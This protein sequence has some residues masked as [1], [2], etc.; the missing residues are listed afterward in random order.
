MNRISSD[1]LLICFWMVFLY[2]LAWSLF[3]QLRVFP[4]KIEFILD[5]GHYLL[6]AGG[7]IDV[8]RHLGSLPAALLAPGF[9]SNIMLDGPVLSLCGAIVLALCGKEAVGSSWPNILFLTCACQALTAGCL[10]VLAGRLCRS[11]RVALIVGL[12]WAVYP[13]AV[14]ASGRFLTE[15]LAAALLTAIFALSSE[16]CRGATRQKQIR[17]AFLTGFMVGAG[18]LLKPVLAPLWLGLPAYALLLSGRDLRPLPKILALALGLAAVMAPWLIYGR[19]ATGSFYL[20]PQRVPA[21]NIAKGHD[22]LADGWSTDPG[23]PQTLTY[24]AMGSTKTILSAWSKNP[25]ALADLYL[26]KIPRTMA[27][28]WNDFRQTIYGLSVDAQNYLHSIIVVLAVAGGL[29]VILGPR[30]GSQITV[31]QTFI[32]NSALALVMVQALLYLPFEAIA[33]YGYCAVPALFLLA[34]YGLKQWRKSERWLIAVIVM[35]AFA[36]KGICPEQLLGSINIFD[37]ALLTTVLRLSLV[38]IILVICWRA[39]GGRNVSLS[40]QLAAV[41][42]VLLLVVAPTFCLGLRR[43]EYQGTKIILGMD[44]LSRRLTLP[45]PSQ[46][47]QLRY[48]L[49][50]DGDGCR[51]AHYWVNGMELDA[52]PVSLNKLDDQYYSIFNLMRINSAISDSRVEQLRQWRVIPVDEALLKFG[53]ENEFSVQGRSQSMTLY[54]DRI[55]PGEKAVHLPDRGISTGYYC[56]G[57]EGAEMRLLSPQAVPIIPSRCRLASLKGQDLSPYVLPRFYLL[58]CSSPTVV[59]RAPPEDIREKLRVSEFPLAFRANQGDEVLNVNRYT[60]QQSGP[61]T[62]ERSLPPALAS[63]PLLKVSLRGNLRAVGRMTKAGV[64]VTVAAVKGNPFMILPDCSPAVECAV[65]GGW[66]AFEIV[67][68]IPS[69]MLAGDGKVIVS[70]LPGRWEQLIQYGVDRTVGSFQFK[71]L[72]LSVSPSSWPVVNGQWKIY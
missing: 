54:A 50:I 12:C 48:F 11:V 33:R 60:F 20:T 39:S 63:W 69:E 45:A 36:V 72:E 31:E 8:F 7:I 26:R 56:N 49:L 55:A 59:K 52:S 70:L 1:R 22:L 64:M 66:H 25:T 18:F 32:T 30:L 37:L 42:T 44:K 61:A 27:F 14:I 28:Q 10:A 41:L 16:L 62:I 35:A 67:D 24:E 40:R 58:S 17:T 34:A 65:G 38:L 3:F 21:H 2:S 46:V 53:G 15:P 51:D 19:L 9:S 23:S 6:T 68:L 5:S 57:N 43:A 4:C 71:D 13:A 29:A 47:D